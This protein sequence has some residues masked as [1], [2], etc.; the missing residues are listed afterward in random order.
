[1]SLQNKLTE[2]GSRGSTALAVSILGVQR[3]VKQLRILQR[4]VIHS[5]PLSLLFCP[6]ELLQAVI[7]EHG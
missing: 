5:T 7:L 1:M 4:L 6:F 3:Q 2:P